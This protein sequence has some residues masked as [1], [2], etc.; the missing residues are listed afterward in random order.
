MQDE[1][2]F[3]IEDIIQN[4]NKKKKIKSGKKGKSAERDIVKD[5]NERF[6][7]YFEQHPEIG[8]F[9]RSLG[10][11]NRFGQKVILS[12]AA[13]ETFTG[14]LSVPT[15]FKFTIESKKGYNDID[16]IDCFKQCKGLDNFL[17]QAQSDANRIKKHP[18]LIW[19]KDRK[20]KIA[21]IKKEITDERPKDCYIVYREWIGV[22][23]KWL[24]ELNDEFFFEKI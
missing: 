18:M 14:D 16:L 2:D 24:L 10:S 22:N 5:L 12:Q 19:R 11:G 21:F 9:S 4:L 23:L 7:S 3:E 8:S 15:G 13:K 6:K 20:E 1:D 17:K